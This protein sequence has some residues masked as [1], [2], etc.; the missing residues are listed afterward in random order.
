MWPKGDS[1]AAIES[2]ALDFPVVRGS[3]GSSAR[4]TIRSGRIGARVRED[5]VANPSWTLVKKS[6]TGPGVEGELRMRARHRTKLLTSIAFTAV[7]GIV[8][9]SMPAR[10]DDTQAEIAALKAQLRRLEEKVDSQAKAA[11]QTRAQLASYPVPTRKG[12]PEILACPVGKF[13]YKGLTITPGGFFALEGVFRNHNLES[14][15][16]TPWNSIPFNNNKIGR[17]S[18]GRLSERQSRLS[19]LVEGK[20]DPVTSLSGYGEFDFLGAAQTANSNES[21]SFNP[22][23]RHLYATIDRSDWGLHV[24]A[25]QTWSLATLSSQGMTPRKEQIPLTIDAQYVPGFTWTRTPEI[26]IVKD[27]GPNFAIGVSAENS[28]TTF[29]GTNPSA[30]TVIATSL[31]GCGGSAAV[32]GSGASNL[33]ACNTYSTNQIP[34]FIA[35]ATFDTSIV[36]HKVHME[37]YGLL[38]DFY[39]RTDPTP[40][41]ASTIQATGNH[42]VLGGG[43]GGGIIVEAIPKFVDLQFSGLTG[44]GIGRYGSAGLPD[45]TYNSVTGS[46]RPI[47][48]TQLLVGGIVHATSW[49]DV[50][51]YAGEEFQSAKYNPGSASGFG[52]GNPSTIALGCLSEFSTA[53][54]ST[55][56]KNI[57]QITVGFWDTIYKG[58]FGMLR[59]GFQY[60]D[61]ERTGFA[62]AATAAPSTWG[63]ITPKGNEQIFMTSLRYYP[64]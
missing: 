13:C 61:T 26:R 28:Q 32:N 6:L 43:F 49:L 2:K 1:G 12:E 55:Q 56:T 34:D 39:D 51:A 62:G 53:A 30:G 31:N 9:G 50:Y 63:T 57:G 42:D 24:L 11:A 47:N 23:V 5:F 7:V 52:V 21:N 45:V 19:L 4:R 8:L 35:K 25:G 58:E 64:F 41:V 37:A 48:E 29:S 60:S 46:L 22:R 27:L 17:T 36:D 59:A 3:F 44:D 10:A 16:A 15:I 14:D 20:V 33:N 54:C 40:G 38:R 18:E